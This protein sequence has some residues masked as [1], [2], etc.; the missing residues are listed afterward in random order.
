MATYNDFRILDIRVGRIIVVENFPETKKASYKLKIDF[1]N[2]IGVKTS[3]AQLVKNYTKEQLR[4]KLVVAVVNFPPKQIGSFISEVLVL[5]VPD[6]NHDCILVT[7][8][9]RKPLLG[10]Q[11]Y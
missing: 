7:P 9:S 8:D 2:E 6:E 10:G 4:G 11:L 3:S 5:G 1:G